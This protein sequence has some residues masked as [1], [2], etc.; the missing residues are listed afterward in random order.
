MLRLARGEYLPLRT[1]ED[2]EVDTAGASIQADPLLGVLGAMIGLP[3]GWRA[4]AQ[5]VVLAPAPS[6]WARAYQRMALERP[7]DQERRADNGPS[8]VGPLAMIGAIGLYQVA[9]MRRPRGAVAI[10]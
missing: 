1:L 5:L 4:L 9:R 7:L 8:L 3:D 2:R 10:G 6:D